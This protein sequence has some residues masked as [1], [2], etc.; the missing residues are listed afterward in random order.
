MKEILIAENSG[1]C[2]GVKQ[3]IEK[4][5]E[6]IKIKDEGGIT[7]R[8]FTCG[9]LIHNR[10]V[11]DDL[12]S[13]GVGIIS[14]VNEA[15][16]GDVVI[17]RS[18]GEGKAFF[19]EAEALG[20]TV[21]DATCPFVKK[22]QMLAEKAFEAGKQVLIV[23]DREHPEVKGINGWCEGK[24]LIVN[25]AEEAEE[26]KGENLFLVCQT[27]IKKELLDE[28][29]EVLGRNEVKFE[30]NNT[31]CSATTLR[32]K[33][34]SELSEKCDAMVVIGGKDSS[35]TRK[36]YQIA[37]K[38]CKNAYFIEKIEDLPL[39]QIEKYNKIGIAAGASTPECV[40]KE[41][42]ATM[43]ENITE[44]NEMNMMDLM[45]DIEKSLRLP[46]IGELGKPFV[47]LLPLNS[48]QGKSRF[49]VFKNG[50]QLLSFDQRIGF[51]TPK[52]MTEPV[53]GSPFASAYFCRD[54]LPR[55]LIVEKLDKYD[56]PLI[57]EETS[58]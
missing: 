3:A 24:A 23:G 37:K 9:P 40:I 46:R 33:S 10:L 2:F 16:P 39:H 25:S 56:R 52:S 22:I 8:I 51:H 44:M 55:D 14:S 31:I 11:T 7:G 49:D 5:E 34:C 41:V 27:T 20:I 50:I 30:A 19:E 45:D 26:I 54:F 15:E 36:L 17:V 29:T 53:E 21:V 57:E 6:Q 12:A 35:N 32:Q 18:H 38:L 58:E 4:T 28:I 1:F 48:L 43:S 13:R 47:I 42:I